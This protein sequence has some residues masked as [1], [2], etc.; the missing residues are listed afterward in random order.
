M[1]QFKWLPVSQMVQK[2]KPEKKR[3]FNGGGGGEG[4]DNSR[5]S[6]G[7]DEDSNMSNLSTA[8]DSLDGPPS[9]SNIGDRWDTSRNF[10]ALTLTALLSCHHKTLNTIEL[11]RDRGRQETLSGGSEDK[12]NKD[13][14][15]KRTMVTAE[16]GIYKGDFSESG[17][18]EGRGEYIWPNGDR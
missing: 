7:M 11:F 9:L 10:V 18:R 5:A 13:G 16:G 14:G 12:D 8:S 3:L 1:K 6:L 15:Q 4:D 17:A 2:K